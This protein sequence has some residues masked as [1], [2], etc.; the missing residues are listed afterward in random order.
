MDG[1]YWDTELHTGTGHIITID[2]HPYSGFGS[3][4]EQE[5]LTTETLRRLGCQRM[6]IKYQLSGNNQRSVIIGE[7]SGMF[8]D[9]AQH[10]LGYRQGGFLDGTHMASTEPHVYQNYHGPMHPYCHFLS[11]GKAERLPLEL[12]TRLRTL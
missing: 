8:T 2:N 11:S 9:C 1:Q 7:W 5:E 4:K 3:K 6:G 10:I 12:K